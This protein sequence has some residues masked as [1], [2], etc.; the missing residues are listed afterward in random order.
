METSVELMAPASA[1]WKL[2]T[3]TLLPYPT[4]TEIRLGFAT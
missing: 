2:L 3:D 4:C 1:A